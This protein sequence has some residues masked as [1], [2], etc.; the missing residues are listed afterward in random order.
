MQIM[1][2]SSYTY[3]AAAYYEKDGVSVRL[4]YS[5][6]SKTPVRIDNYY[7]TNSRQWQQARGTLDATAGYKIFDNLEVRFDVTNILNDDDYIMVANAVPGA[8][9]YGGRYSGI[10]DNAARQVINYV[11]GRS[12][13]LSLRG[14]L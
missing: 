1:G 3:S 8:T 9:Q 5:W 7:S 14:S 4:S 10:A 12:Y 2:L 13:T 11:H 6:R